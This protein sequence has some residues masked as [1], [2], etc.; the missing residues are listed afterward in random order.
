MRV[1][2]HERRQEAYYVAVYA[3]VDKSEFT[4][5]INL[6]FRAGA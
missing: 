4:L 3:R 6:V 2:H 1:G 5:K